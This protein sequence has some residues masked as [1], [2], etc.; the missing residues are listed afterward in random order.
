MMSSS[1]RFDLLVEFEFAIYDRWGQVVFMTSAQ[2]TWW[3]G[4]INGSEAPEGVYFYHLTGTDNQEEP[5][6]EKGSLNLLR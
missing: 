4:T 6:E 1:S 5:V 3:D 2:D